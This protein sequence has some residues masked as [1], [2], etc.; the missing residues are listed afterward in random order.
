MES[1][2]KK[3]AAKANSEF[4]GRFHQNVEDE[5]KALKK[6]LKELGVQS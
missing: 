1:K 6:Q 2:K 5:E 4:M 3:K